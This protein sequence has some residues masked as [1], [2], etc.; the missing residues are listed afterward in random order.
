MGTVSII[1]LS[2]RSTT[3]ESFQTRSGVPFSPY[4]ATAVKTAA[5]L[6]SA[7]QEAFEREDNHLNTED[8]DVHKVHPGV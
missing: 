7:L 1:L 4:S 6:S 5:Q 8:L 3:N 2:S